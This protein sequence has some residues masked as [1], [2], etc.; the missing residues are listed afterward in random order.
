[1]SHIRSACLRGF[2][3]VVAELGGD[4]DDLALS[5]GLAPESLDTDD[6]LLPGLAAAALLEVASERLRCPNLGLRIAAR[7]SVSVLGTLAVAITNSPTMGDALECLSRYLFVHGRFL[8]LSFGDDPQHRPG[9]IG[10]YYGP[11]TEAGPVQAVDLGIGFIHRVIT[12]LDNGPY[13]LRGMHLPYES[14]VS[15]RDYAA[16]F[17][18]PVRTRQPRRAAVL[19]LPA[20]LPDRELAGVDDTIRQL[21]IAFLAEQSANRG[22]DIVSRTRTAIRESLG[23]GTVELVGI[24][25]LLMMHPRSLQR[26]LN[27]AGV[28]FG[29]LLD[30]T[31]RESALRL[32][33]GTDLPLGHIAGIVGFVEQPSFSRA[34][35]RWWG[36]APSEVRRTRR[37]RSAR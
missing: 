36:I 37:I 18:A 2:R 17:G 19:R 12:Y 20:E 35:R 7:Q 26:H 28:T 16:F 14:P 3:T 23:T 33:L 1:M 27:E 31:R 11:A 13:G 4:A 30:D 21:A 24:S 10:L 34:A 8:T 29:Q 6:D 25:R 22:G 5:V 9:V 15:A 32:L